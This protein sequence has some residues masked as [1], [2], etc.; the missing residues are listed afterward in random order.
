M[1][2]GIAS[3]RAP[4][5]LIAALALALAACA[6]PGEQVAQARQ[7]WQGAA[8]EDV[9]RAWGVPARTATLADGREARTWVSEVNRSRGVIYPS[10]G[11]FGG[12]GNVGVGVGVATSAP[13]GQEVERCERSLVFAGERVVESGPWSGPEAYCASFR[14]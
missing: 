7:S 10:V 5:V 14:R 13:F 2:A 1:E 8:Y 3:A 11:V 4:E 9:V 12:S 6:T